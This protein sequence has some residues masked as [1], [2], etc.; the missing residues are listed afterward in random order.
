MNEWNGMISKQYHWLNRKWNQIDKNLS[1]RT[2]SAHWCVLFNLCFS[3]QKSKKTKEP[4]RLIK[5]ACMG[6]SVKKSE[7]FSMKS[8]R[9][10]D[11]NKNSE[12]WFAER[13]GL[14][15]GNIKSNNREEKGWKTKKGRQ[16][17]EDKAFEEEEC[18]KLRIQCRRRA[19]GSK[20][21]QKTS[22]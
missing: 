5:M 6:S 14:L 11:K 12:F 1:W 18:E 3:W 7:D 4:N 15:T 21:T 10:K 20:E 9:G 8:I 2:R 22:R 17:V 16:A 19:D 13:N